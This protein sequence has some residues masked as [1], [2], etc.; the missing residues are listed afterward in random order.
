MRDSDW[1]ILHTLYQTR[2][3]T[4][5]AELL[6]MTQ[7]TLTKRLQRI[8]SEWQLKLLHRGKTGVA[9]TPEGE[10]LAREADTMV[11]YQ[12]RIRQMT[13]S[14]SAGHGGTI[15]VGANT[16][17]SRYVLPIRLE[18][19]RRLKPSVSFEISTV[20][21][22]MILEKLNNREIDIGIVSGDVE[23]NGVAKLVAL[24]QA[25]IISR[26]PIELD[27]LTQLP[28]IRQKYAPTSLKIF[29]EWWYEVFSQPP[30]IGMYVDQTSVCYDMA[31]RGLG[32]A[33]VLIPPSA[34][35]EIH[36]NKIPLR[37]KNGQPFLRNNWA[38]CRENVYDI[39][40]IRD[41]V[42]FLEEQR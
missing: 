8:E 28:Q 41:F 9:F 2:N 3:I 12:R 19:Y 23:Y 1:T 6:Y 21:T 4:R 10:Y 27:Q 24:D 37:R 22:G 35:T 5:A 29:D 39:A 30:I 34:A 7:P 15:R 42:S 26:D 11:A 16:A 25:Y 14:I 31:E 17:F 32:Y 36:L 33:I 38:L 18:H 40:L 13:A 20:N